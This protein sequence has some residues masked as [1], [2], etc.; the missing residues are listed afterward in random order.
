MWPADI[1]FELYLFIISLLLIQNNNFK[2]F[3]CTEDSFLSVLDQRV[4]LFTPRVYIYNQHDSSQLIDDQKR[5][6][7]WTWHEVSRSSR[8]SLGFVL[9]H[10]SPR[11]LTIAVD[12]RAEVPAE[13]GRDRVTWT[14]TW[15]HRETDST[16]R[17]LMESCTSK[18]WRTSSR[19]WS[20][21]IPHDLSLHYTKYKTSSDVKTTSLHTLHEKTHNLYFSLTA[22]H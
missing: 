6:C 17:C 2:L 10:W 22:W 5:G 18:M 4:S 13:G 20:S 11:F 16:L 3:P 14:E 8:F 19:I 7:L 9:H 1:A 15:D 12:S 21:R